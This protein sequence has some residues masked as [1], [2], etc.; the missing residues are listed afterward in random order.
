MSYD[1]REV[2]FK[3]TAPCIYKVITKP[4]GILLF[5]KR[6]KGNPGQAAR[7]S[8]MQHGKMRESTMNCDA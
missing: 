8:S 6:R 4:A 2:S 1:P 7:Q 5:W 3:V